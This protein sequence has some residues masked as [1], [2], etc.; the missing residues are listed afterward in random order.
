M[1]YAI[2]VKNTLLNIISD[3]SNRPD[4][5]SKHPGSDFTRNRKLNLKDLLYLSVAMEA[6]TTRD[7]LYKFFHYDDN[8]LT[9]SA[10]IQQRSKL[11]SD[12][13]PYLF[14]TF[15]KNFKH[16][17][18]KDK[19]QLLACDGSSFTFTR[20]PKDLES[21]YQPSDKS[22]KGFNQIHV[23]PLYDIISKRYTDCIIQPV[24]KKNEFEALYQLID[25]H[26]PEEGSTPIY[27]ADRGFHAWNVFAHAIE[28]GS[29]FL[30][31]AKAL[32]TKRAL[33]TDK[34]S[35]CDEYDIPITRILTRSAAKRKRLHPELA[36]QY[37]Y[38]CKEVT[39]DYINED[40]PEY[41]IS[42]RVLR[43]KISDDIYENI[44]TNLPEEEFSP[45]EIKKIY[46][47]RWQIEISFKDLK[48]SLGA[49]N[50][51][52][53]KR[54]FIEME[55]WAKLL[56]YNFSSIIS[57][58]IAIKQKNRK[59][60]YQI[61]FRMAFKVCHYFIRQKNDEIP[62]NVKCLI[63]QHILPI[64]PDRKFARQHRFRVPVNFIYR[65]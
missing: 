4:D 23:V 65:F 14:Y 18:Y 10:F 28:Q 30:I 60:T 40:S 38:I 1:N 47:L 39:F 27:I 49:M 22:S 34:P 61:N 51:H 25:S 52:S 57:T 35:D 12:A 24:R 41:S 7:E 31:R 17:L 21:Y 16:S 33:G 36:D 2:N 32:N 6:G 63:E 44:I 29:Y 19:Y 53:K 13:L 48:H 3:M 42:L 46:N 11:S 59:Y 58:H 5:F 62:I 20:N 26:L 56:L 55:I 8:T 45:D 9:P 15:N 37:R 43:I 64:R 54:E 50:F